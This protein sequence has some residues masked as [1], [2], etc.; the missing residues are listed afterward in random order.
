MLS[1]I[2]VVSAII[3]IIITCLALFMTKKRH[4][5]VQHRTDNR[6]TS[7]YDNTKDIKK[8]PT[9]SANDSP[10]EVPAEFI[11]PDIKIQDLASLDMPSPTRPHNKTDSIIID[12][13]RNT[14][15][16]PSAILEISQAVNN[17]ETHIKKLA[18][19]ISTDPVLSTKILRLANSPAISAGKVTS[20]NTA[21]M[22][23]GLNQVSIIV[24]QMLTSSTIKSAF[25]IPKEDL[26]KIWKHSA[27]V[28]CCTRALTISITPADLALVASVQTCALLHDI[29]KFYLCGIN[30]TGMAATNNDDLTCIFSE[31]DIYGTDH[32]HIGYMLADFW[33]LPE[34]ISL[35]IGFHHH[36][37][38]NNFKEVPSVAKRISAIV[39]LGDYMANITGHGTSNTTCNIP[40]QQAL[41]EAGITKTFASFFNKKLI[42]EI[43]YTE[44]LISEVEDDK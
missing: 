28:A 37:S 25:K 32:S 40:V 29:G 17:S 10:D 36:I 23:L 15:E 4:A 30:P 44:M 38:F 7:S 8:T 24:N 26:L 19:L 20:I 22:L 3:V 9:V 39:A 16:I 35:S 34:V 27:A 18:E 14:A 42:Q 43:Q 33:E 41:T 6:K 2:I 21:I 31:M 12:M 1:T 13:L 5:T 11:A